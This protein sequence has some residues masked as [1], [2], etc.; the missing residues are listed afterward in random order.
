MNLIGFNS[1]VNN[2]KNRA[3]T[4]SV[5]NDYINYISLYIGICIP[6]DADVKS[7]LDFFWRHL[8]LIIQRAQHNIAQHSSKLTSEEEK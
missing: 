4:E 7:L 8:K 5:I 6:E 1:L 3:E 2:F